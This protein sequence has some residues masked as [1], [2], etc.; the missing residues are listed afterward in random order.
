[1]VMLTGGCGAGVQ[2]RA[3]YGWKC[4]LLWNR[5]QSSLADTNHILKTRRK[6]M[7]INEGNYVLQSSRRQKIQIFNGTLYAAQTVNFLFLSKFLLDF[8]K[9]KSSFYSD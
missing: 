3:K 8:T 2:L 6:K 5:M 7:C 4:I 9:H 1:M